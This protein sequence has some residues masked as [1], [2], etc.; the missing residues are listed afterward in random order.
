MF[1][2]KVRITVI[3]GRGGDGDA[4]SVRKFIGLTDN[5][6]IKRVFKAVV[7]R[8]LKATPTIFTR[9]SIASMHTRKRIWYLSGR[10][11]CLIRGNGFCK[12]RILRI[13]RI[14]SNEKKP[15]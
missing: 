3:G 6:I 11:A 13:V 12:S 1:V 7:L 8:W 4:G 10:K 14:R 9:F 15:S 5:E 2:D